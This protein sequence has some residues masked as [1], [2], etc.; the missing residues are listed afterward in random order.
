MTSNPKQRSP[1]LPPGEKRIRMTISVVE[2][3]RR[4]A[5]KEF[6]GMTESYAVEQMV[7]TWKRDS[8]KER[9]P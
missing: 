3:V 5:A 4:K 9:K 6:P 1:K 8:K 2:A 7:L